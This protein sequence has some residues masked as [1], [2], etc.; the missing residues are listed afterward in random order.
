MQRVICKRGMNY[1]GGRSKSRL[2]LKSESVRIGCTCMYCSFFRRVFVAVALL[3][4][5][6]IRC[7]RKNGRSRC[8]GELPETCQWVPD[9]LSEETMTI[10]MNARP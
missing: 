10:L 7:G 6:H 8:P 4:Q 9:M 1:M 5:R 3:D 2:V